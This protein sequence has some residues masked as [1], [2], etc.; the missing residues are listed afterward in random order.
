[1]GDPT[2]SLLPQPATPAPIQAMHGG[3]MGGGPE[4]VSLLAQPATP[5][6]ITPVRGGGQVGGANIPTLTLKANER[7]TIVGEGLTLLTK[8]LLNK[9]REKRKTIW[10]TELPSNYE[11]SR[12][13]LFHY[14]IKTKE[15][16]KIFYIYSYDNFLRFKK[17]IVNDKIKKNNFIYIFFSKLDNNSI[18][19][20]EIFKLYI[21]FITET[22]AE[23]FLLYDRAALVNQITW[24]KEHREDK[25]KKE[26]LLLEPAS[27]AIPYLKE[28][29][30]Y[31]L[32]LSPTGVAPP[33]VS[34]DYIGL[35]PKNTGSDLLKFEQKD[36]EY[37]PKSLF[38][39][40]P[41][42]F[43]AVDTPKTPINGKEYLRRKY[44]LFTFEDTEEEEET[45]VALEEPVVAEEPV[46]AKEP[47]VA[48][49]VS[50]EPKPVVTPPPLQP[51]PYVLKLKGTVA[52]RIGVAVFELRKPTL[53]VQ[54]EW[55][56]GTFSD[57]EKAFFADIGITE[58]FIESAK[59]PAP[60]SELKT[61]KESLLK[62]RSE[63]LTRLVMNRCFKEQNLLL[64]HECEPVREFLQELYELV[65][66]DRA[67]LFRKTFAGIAPA[68]VNL[69]K[70]KIGQIIFTRKEIMS[71]LE[72]LVPISKMPKGSSMFDIP[73]LRMVGD[74]VGPG[75][76]PAAPGAPPGP[77]SPS[78]PS[79]LGGL[80]AI[81]KPGVGSVPTV[82]NPIGLSVLY[83]TNP[84]SLA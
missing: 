82:L 45:E 23:V 41:D 19:F 5:A 59:G 75:S 35:T 15:P 18:D 11:E 60:L 80:A 58:K 54:K 79:G 71:L 10:G 64:A 56:E 9:Y 69:Q 6:P 26:F 42:K 78:G 50:A 53:A 46:E 38:K 8:D 29:K 73:F 65:Q 72:G 16:V 36:G 67:N 83:K 7:V 27:I 20:S 61:R 34:K 4:T 22:P 55:D 77:G 28:G 1:M 33:Q 66:I 21:K 81:T 40:T 57:S 68:I 63:V 51:D 31:K 25:A 62:K 84:S 48:E 17:T 2:V 70:Q 47:V 43:Y 12:A 3:G 74:L 32:L 14:E 24:N 39:L 52:V 49:V 44:V 30:E 76:G 13:K 37:K